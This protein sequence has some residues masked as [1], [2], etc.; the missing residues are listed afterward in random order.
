MVDWIGGLAVD[1]RGATEVVR[2]L[3]EI[4][5]E[6]GFERVETEGDGDPSVV[7]DERALV[8]SGTKGW[9]AVYIEM[10][11]KDL[12]MARELSQRLGAVVLLHRSIL[13]DAVAL[14]WFASGDLMDEFQSCPDYFKGWGEPDAG[15]GELERTAG[16]AEVAKTLV[17]RIDAGALDEIYRECRMTDLAEGDPPAMELG[18]AL[19]KLRKA[20][21]VGTFEHGFEDLW[22]GDFSFEARFLAWRRP[23][24]T[25]LDRFKEMMDQAR[26]A[27]ERFAMQ[28]DQLRERM[29][30]LRARLG[31]KTSSE[32]PESGSDAGSDNAEPAKSESKSGGPEAGSPDAGSPEAGSPDAGSP[33]AGSPDAGSP[34]AG[35][36]DSADDAGEER[37]S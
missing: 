6:A 37:G 29:D 32:T 23:T 10:P 21:G 7:G 16:Q 28:T 25:R 20:T 15:E 30:Q 4:Y 35:G 11:D 5:T 9:T 17:S 3:D 1:G 14:F 34:D 24:K 36:P 19:R 8:I 27:R 12:L 33:D 31:V 22:W 13:F 26:G 18:V 2:V